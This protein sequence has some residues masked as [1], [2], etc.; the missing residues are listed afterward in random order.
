MKNSKVLPQFAIGEI[1]VSYKKKIETPFQKITSSK[2]ADSC[3]REI[4]PV[5]QI[6]YR[7]HMYVLYLDNANKVLAYQL[8]SVGGIT[9]TL[10]DIRIL[11]QGALL[12]NSVALIL[13][14]NH[15]SGKLKPSNADIELT[16]KVSS[17]LGLL[18]LKLLDHL[19]IT[20]T[21]YY[22][23]ADQGMI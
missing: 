14:H 22:S 1:E 13:F 21:S 2:D 8:L 12:T 10:L 7:E 23:F 16:K 18:D 5:T 19:I 3:I 20:E 15:P 6:N 9:A 17:S 4:F 11:I